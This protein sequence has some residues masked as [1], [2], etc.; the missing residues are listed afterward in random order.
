MPF[1]EYICPLCGH[2]FEQLQKFSD[3]P[4]T[5]C[6]SCHKEGLQKKISAPAFHLKGSGWYV[7]DFK[8]KKPADTATNPASDKESKSAS[9]E[10]VEP[11]TTESKK[12]EDSSKIE[13]TKSDK[14]E[15]SAKKKPDG[16]S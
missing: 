2:E 8:D 15:T 10:A 7:T 3:A 16:E 4:L 9:S 6:P 11:A 5:T 13:T 14:T 12:T 1:Y